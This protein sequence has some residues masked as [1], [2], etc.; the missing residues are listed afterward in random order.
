MDYSKLKRGELMALAKEMWLPV[1]NTDTKADLIA[2]ITNEWSGQ[3]V[4]P[5]K[6]VE[7]K[8]MRYADKILAKEI[9]KQEKRNR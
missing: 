6:K 7:K 8:R 2:K 3:Q 4:T 5:E 1:A 9:K